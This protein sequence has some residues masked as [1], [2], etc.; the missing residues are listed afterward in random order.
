MPVGASSVLDQKTCLTWTKDKSAMTMTNKQAFKYC[1]DLNQDGISDWRVPR[2]E[3]LVTWPNIAATDTAYITGPIYIP[4]NSTPMDGC[5]GNSHSCNISEYNANSFACAWQG[6]AFLGW[7]AC[8]SGT[9]NAGT[10]KTEFSASTCAAC[11][12][13]TS[14]FKEQDC[15]AYQ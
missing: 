11:T 10:T 13:S 7:V 6:V 4:S 1:D 12:E 15:S 2:P 8:V 3:E 9:A 14:S 5:T